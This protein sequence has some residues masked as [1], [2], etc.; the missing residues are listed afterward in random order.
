L[1][2]IKRGGAQAPPLFILFFVYFKRY[3][4]YGVIV[5]TNINWVGSGG[6]PVPPVNSY[7]TSPMFKGALDIHWGDPSGISGNSGWNIVGVNIYRSEGSD[8]GPFKRLNVTPLGGGFYRDIIANETITET[9]P[10][11]GWEAKGDAPSRRRWIFR[12]QNPIVKDDITHLVYAN[13]AFDVVVTVDGVRSSVIS[14]S[15]M[16]RVVE[17]SN[18]SLFNPVIE[19]FSPPVL[20]VDANS[21]VTITYKTNR[22]N[23]L[24]RLDGKVFYRLT[25]VAVSK[26]NPDEFIES[27]LKSSKPLT[28]MEVETLD[29]IWKEAIRRNNW[30]LEQG[31]ERVKI[32]VRN[33]NGIPCPCT[34]ENALRIVSKQPV[35]NCLMC[36]GTGNLGG[37]SGPYDSIIAVGDTERKV[38]QTAFGRKLDHNYEVFMGP[39]PLVTQRDFIVK[40]TNERYSI[41]P[42]RRPTNRGNIMQQ[43]FNVALLEEGDIKY[44][45][46]LDSILALPFPETRYLLED[47]VKYRE[48][49]EYQSTPMGGENSARVGG[50]PHRGRTPTWENHN[51]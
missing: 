8:L 5:L 46:H 38:S 16:D 41:G 7:V 43:H 19:R 50:E 21:V 14:V 6:Y 42:V 11:G 4:L 26:D 47:D 23:F 18:T 2:N 34:Y 51:F 49:S 3:I 1:S 10:W 13:S 48:G 37:Y 39:S 35:N 22:N 17:L 20:P 31:G 30:I 9:I 36:Y 32:F 33:F 29:W 44:K 24:V 28:H 45:V 12:T 15:G 27:P 25:T 40:Q